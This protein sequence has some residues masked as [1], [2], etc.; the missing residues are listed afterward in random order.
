MKIGLEEPS[1]KIGWEY[2]R[3]RK[4][5]ELRL[6]G[7]LSKGLEGSGEEAELSLEGTGEPW[8]VSSRTG[9]G[10]CFSRSTLT[11]WLSWSS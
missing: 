3:L 8:Q 11:A 2:L 5:L 10:S 7:E 6:A 4:V 1:S 9:A